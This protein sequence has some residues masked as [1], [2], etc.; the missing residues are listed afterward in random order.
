M[1]GRYKINIKIGSLVKIEEQENKGKF[2]IGNVK[3][4][5]SSNPYESEGQMV[6]LDN[7]SVGRV[8]EVFTIDDNSEGAYFHDL[9]HIKNE[10]EEARNFLIEGNFRESIRSAGYQIEELVTKLSS[11]PNNANFVDKVK[12]LQQSRKYEKF[13]NDLHYLRRKRNEYSHPTNYNPTKEDAMIVLMLANIVFVQ[14][15]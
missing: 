7:T 13:A 12:Q 11:L 15:S 9:S 14:M 6:K 2:V 4:K 5:I 3:E 10:L 8:K 1:D